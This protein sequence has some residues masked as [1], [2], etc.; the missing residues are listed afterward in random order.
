[1]E[2]RSFADGLDAGVREREEAQMTGMLGPQGEGSHHHQRDGEDWGWA[3][4]VV[5]WLLRVG[6][7]R[8]EMSVRLLSGDDEL[9]VARS[10]HGG[11]G[12]W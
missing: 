6:I 1:M 4:W 8:R 9:Q 11:H 5:A 3:S 10:L 2:P 12:R 7:V